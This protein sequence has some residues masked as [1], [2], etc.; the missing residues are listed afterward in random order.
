MKKHNGRMRIPLLIHFPNGEFAGRIRSNVQN[1]DIPPTILDYVGI[2]HPGWMTG[3]SLLKGD[4][5]QDRLIFNSGPSNGTQIGQDKIEVDAKPVKLLSYELSF[6][7][8]INCQKWYKLNLID[9][10]WSSGDIQG[11]S[12]P[13]LEDNLLTMEQVNDALTEHLLSNGFDTSTLQ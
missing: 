5:P 9:L 6:Y 8:V 13:C 12:S 2:E 3:Q 7:N 11:H 1:L 10:T 4:P